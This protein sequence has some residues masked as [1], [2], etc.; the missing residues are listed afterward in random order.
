MRIFSVAVLCGFLSSCYFLQS[1]ETEFWG[2]LTALCGNSYSGELI[3]TDEQDAAFGDGDLY[4]MVSSCERKKVVIDFMNSGEAVGHWALTKHKNQIELRHIHEGAALT[5]YG[6]YSTDYSSGSR[7][8]FPADDATKAL[9]DAE[10]IPVSKD[11]IWAITIFP[12]SYFQY[13][14]TRPG[15]EFIVEFSTNNPIQP[16]TEVTH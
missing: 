16:E 5:G 15:R 3:S 8:N 6:G 13:E 11:N 14:L 7:M 4:M 9:F 10:D 12:G 1:P 2:R